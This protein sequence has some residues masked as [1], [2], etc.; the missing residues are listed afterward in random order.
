[1]LWIGKLANVVGTG[2][3]FAAPIEVRSNE[4]PLS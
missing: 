2:L 3:V 1:M 4:W